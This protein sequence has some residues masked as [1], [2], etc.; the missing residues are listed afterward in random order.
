MARKIRIELDHEGFRQLLSGPEVT[1]LVDS[2]GARL[3]AKAGPGFV[4]VPAHGGFGGGRHIC[5]VGTG[6]S[7]EAM[8]AQARGK[9]LTR[10]LY[11]MGGS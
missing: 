6:D 4:S 8:E 9:A 2:T 3:A 5:H 1:Q 11:S 10:A 7:K